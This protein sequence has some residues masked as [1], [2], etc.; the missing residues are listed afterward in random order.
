M[1]NTVVV[2]AQWGDEGKGRIVDLLALQAD[3]VCRFQGGANAGHTIKVGK[4]EF[5]LH[6][7]PSGAL[8]PGKLCLIGNGV[9]LDP[10]AL[11]DEVRGLEKRGIKTRGRLFVSGLCHLTLPYHRLLDEAREKARGAKKI[12]TTHKGIGPT[13][14]DKM[15]RSGIRFADLFLPRAF[16]EKVRANVSEKNFLL[17]KYY[18]FKTVSAGAIMT[19]YARMRGKLKPYLADTSR[20]LAEAISQGKSILFE[21]AQGTFLDVDY[22]TYPFVTASNTIAGG[23][24]TGAGVGPTKIHSV[25][26]VAKAYTTRV[27]AGPFPTEFP[28]ALAESL[29]AR[30]N[31][32]GATTGRP[33]RC[34]HFDAVMVRHAVRVSG[35][36][37]LAITKLDVLDEMIKVKVCTGYKYKGRI[38]K[39]Y[40]MA[41][42]VLERCQPVYE[43]LKG[44]HKPTRGVRSWFDLPVQARYYLE[45]I[46]EK[47]E[48]RISIVSVGSEREETIWVTR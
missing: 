18:R 4:E 11:L 14:Q 29:R 27:G 33:R 6:L 28:G 26:G 42:S 23:A 22:G 25:L 10:R 34:G 5:V 3:V 46:A 31:E 8:Y 47:T 32:F 48:A 41:T 13:Y 36:D 39:D 24:C 1:P 9:A 12:G 43:E 19:S 38:L 15:G 17:S 7:V 44:W 35:M 2:G 30:G 20:M 16:G 40:P 21:G 45:K 37:S